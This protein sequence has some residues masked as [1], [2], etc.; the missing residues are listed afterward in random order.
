[1]LKGGICAEKGG[2]EQGGDRWGVICAERGDLGGKIICIRWSGLG[3]FILGREIWGH[4]VLRRGIC[5]ERGYMR[6]MTCAERGYL[7]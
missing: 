3:G 6:V 4:F 7:C 2:S 1:M 5:A